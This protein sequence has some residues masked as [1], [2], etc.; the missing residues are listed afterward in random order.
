MV[1]PLVANS[2]DKFAV[3]TAVKIG[4]LGTRYTICRV[5]GYDLNLD[6][7]LGAPLAF[8]AEGGHG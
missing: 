3:K 4:V 1:T 6:S 2:L 5:R 8:V 7:K